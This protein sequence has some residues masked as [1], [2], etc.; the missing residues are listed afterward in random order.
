MLPSRGRTLAFLCTKVALAASASGTHS[1][2]RKT[3]T[4]TILVLVGL[5]VRQVGKRPP[6]P[7][8]LLLPLVVDR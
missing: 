5:R 3:L 6:C 1:Q 4:R 2:T 8:A 7:L